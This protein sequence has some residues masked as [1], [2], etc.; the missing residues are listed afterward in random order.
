[1]NKKICFFGAGQICKKALT[2]AKNDNMDIDFIVDNNSK[3]WETDIN[4]MNIKSPEILKDVHTKYCIIVT[5]GIKNFPEIRK[6]LIDMNFKENIDFF[7]YMD[8]FKIPCD[9]FGKHSGVLNILDGFT[10]IKGVSKNKVTI[11]TEDKCIYRFMSND[12]CE[13]SRLVYNTI[14]KNKDLQKY[15]VK[16]NIV[17]EKITDT[18]PIVYQHEYIPFFTYVPE[19]TPLMFY[20][21]T[22]F[23]T[24][25]LDELDKCGLGLCD[26][27]PFNATFYKGDFIFFDFEAI[28]AEK[29]SYYNMKFFINDY[30][31]ICLVFSLGL[32][33]K[34]YML[35]NAIRENENVSIKDICGYLSEEEIKKFQTLYDRCYELSL[36]N[37]INECCKL[38]R[39]YLL[40]MKIK[41]D[42]EKTGQWIGYQDELYDKSYL[43][44]TD[45]QKSIVDMVKSVKPTTI[46]D[47]AGNMGWYGFAL[48]NDV[49]YCITA[50]IDCDCIDFVFNKVRNEGVKNIYPMRLN[51]VVP[52]LATYY[53]GLIGNTAIVPVCK[54]AIDRCRC[55]MVLALAIIHHLVFRQLMSFKECVE[56][57]ALYTSKYLIIEFVDRND[58]I[59][60]PL[61]KDNK[62]FDWYTKENFEAE[63]KK[64]FYIKDIKNTNNINK[65]RILYL[66]EKI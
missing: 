29:T 26:M 21:Y 10:T 11:S 63:L 3:I 45:K 46:L 36:D 44:W 12:S 34:A 22:L 57:L 52:T 35:L 17:P 51:L 37:N 28:A 27:H 15:I 38:V 23:M 65:S 40:D 50:D 60:E 25:F 24:D 42:T 64:V 30:V 16:T 59:V 2:Y 18:Y 49:E 41:F 14:I 1:M 62:N 58:V 53:G 9:N 47:L 33:Y 61:V 32:T 4:G 66:C 48:H 56:Q 7:N 39:N 55:E 20:N 5:V 31:L 43:N 13:N 6:Q 8:V 54:S 19:W